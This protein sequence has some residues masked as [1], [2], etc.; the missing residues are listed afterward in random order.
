VRLLVVS[1]Y[2]TWPPVTGGSVRTY[3]LCRHLSDRG[4]TLFLSNAR[5][6]G[7]RPMLREVS[8]VRGPG[9]P[10][11]VELFDYREY[12]KPEIFFNAGLFFKLLNLIRRHDIEWII[13]EF[14][15]QGFLVA[16]I[17]RITGRPFLLDEHN[18]EF[19]RFRQLG[20]T[21]AARLIKAAEG[22]AVRKAEEVFVVSGKEQDLIERT[23]GRRPEL[24][25]N[26]VDTER[27]RPAPRDALKTRFGMGDHFVALF[28][29]NLR[30]SPNAEAVSFINQ[31]L[32][33]VV[34]AENPMVRFIIAGVQPPKL[35]YHP[36]VRAV[37]L[38]DR[39]ED[40][41]NMADVVIVPLE[42]GGGTR[43]KILE[44]LAC[45]ASIISTPVGAEGLD[46]E[47]G[48]DA[49]IAPISE[50][51]RIILRFAREGEVGR[52][53]GRGRLVAER[54]DWSRTLRTI[55]DYLEQRKAA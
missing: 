53:A 24:A 4:H 10:S 13:Q 37:G 40:Y 43:I 41:I 46:L 29:G 39:I 48:V 22:I 8:R 49:E 45:G 54:Y 42:R 31:A 23:F 19:A 9:L 38:V 18:V 26:G 52:F 36:S 55:G 30:Y 5:P 33:P 14:A 47:A 27:F 21:L 50:F 3:E 28:F 12:I 7:L 34:F 15:M 2:P 32:A 44:S 11:R 17:S 35:D 25:P 6:T 1:P 16:L 51:A 20:R